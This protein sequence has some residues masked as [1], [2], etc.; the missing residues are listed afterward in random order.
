MCV[1]ATTRHYDAIGIEASIG[2]LCGA[3][4]RSFAAGARTR[5][6]VGTVVRLAVVV[7]NPGRRLCLDAAANQRNPDERQDCELVARDADNVLHC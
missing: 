3:N 1:N 4:K 2:F 5:S 6:V 7:I